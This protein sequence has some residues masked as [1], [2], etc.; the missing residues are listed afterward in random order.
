MKSNLE[1][2]NSFR[3]GDGLAPFADWRKA[4]HQPMLDAY[5]AAAL[6]A[7]PPEPAM[8]NPD[9][10]AHTKA[11]LA[12]IKDD[13]AKPLSYKHLARKAPAK[14]AVVSPV[15]FVHAFLTGTPGMPRKEA[16]A[17]L[18][19]A[20]VNFSTART[21]YQKWFAANKKA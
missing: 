6:A 15:E 17:A 1:L 14:S 18:V 21:Q 12:K 11:V 7:L 3:E 19:D 5:M 2:L 8:P 10:N 13:K 9:P 4:R 20:G 16:I